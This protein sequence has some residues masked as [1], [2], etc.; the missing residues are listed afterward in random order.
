MR[1]RFS[2]NLPDFVVASLYMATPLTRSQTAAL[3]R[4]LQALLERLKDREL[5]AST[6]I[7]LRIEGAVKALQIVLGE[8]DLTELV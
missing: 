6:G 7:L 5:E 3:T 4:D 8:A 2:R 1:A